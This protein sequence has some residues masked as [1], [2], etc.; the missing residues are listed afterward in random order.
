MVWLFYRHCSAQENKNT[1]CN[2]AWFVTGTETGSR[3]SGAL[4]FSVAGSPFF[5]GLT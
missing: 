5:A 2:I 4:F 1:D 3:V